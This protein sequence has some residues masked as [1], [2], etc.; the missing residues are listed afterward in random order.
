MITRKQVQIE[1]EARCFMHEVSESNLYNASIKKYKNG[2]P[3]NKHE[4]VELAKMIVK[5]VGV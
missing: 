3:L 5:S 1:F 4:K 2:E